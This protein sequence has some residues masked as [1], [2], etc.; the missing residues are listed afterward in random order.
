M[1]LGQNIPAAPQRLPAPEQASLAATK[2]DAAPRSFQ[3]IL[4][5]QQGQ[6]SPRPASERQGE[7]LRAAA[8]SDAVVPMSTLQLAGRGGVQQGASA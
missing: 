1:K 7:G 4:A 3:H 8:S 6:V 2:P 5:D